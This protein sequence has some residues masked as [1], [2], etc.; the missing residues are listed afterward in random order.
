MFQRHRPCL[1][2]HV[3][4][5][6]QLFRMKKLTTEKINRSGMI[7]VHKFDNFLR[8]PNIIWF[9]WSK[10]S[11]ESENW[12]VVS[13]ES[14]KEFELTQAYSLCKGRASLRG[15]RLVADTVLYKKKQHH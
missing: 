14:E 7:L 5:V 9:E 4:I 3:A 8:P 11:W 2:Y 1:R 12:E 15:V 6:M 10:F 13:D